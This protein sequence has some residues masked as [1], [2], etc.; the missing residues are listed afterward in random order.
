MEQNLNY[1]IKKRL[2]SIVVL[3]AFITSAFCAVQTNAAG[4]VKLSQ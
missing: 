1:M 3:T 2:V 4:K